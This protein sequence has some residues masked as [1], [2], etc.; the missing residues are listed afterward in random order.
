MLANFRHFQIF[1]SFV[2]L[3][4]LHDPNIAQMDLSKRAIGMRDSHS[5]WFFSL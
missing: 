2:V 1:R 3:F 5:E 4:V